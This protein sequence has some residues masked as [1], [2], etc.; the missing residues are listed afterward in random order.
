[1]VLHDL[2]LAARYCDHLIAVWKGRLHSAGDPGDVLTPEM[3]QEVFGM[4]SQVIDDPVSGKPIVLPI[5]RHH[6]RTSQKVVRRLARPVRTG[7]QQG[8]QERRRAT[9]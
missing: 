8:P 7:P 9:P 4:Q 1:M 6:A 3:V 2:D 5:G